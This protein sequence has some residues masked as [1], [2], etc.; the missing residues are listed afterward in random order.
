MQ[1]GKVLLVTGLDT[2]KMKELLESFG[3]Q[4]AIEEVGQYKL[5]T[6]SDKEPRST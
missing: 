2:S 6:I 3:K 1:A 5:V 4:L